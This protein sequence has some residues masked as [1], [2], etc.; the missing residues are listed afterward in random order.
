MNARRVRPA[1]A[2]LAIVVLGALVPAVADAGFVKGSPGGGDPYFPKAG[3]GGYEVSSYNLRLRYKPASNHLAATAVIHARAKKSL[4]RFDLDFRHLRIKRLAVN[5]ERARY[6][7]RG[8][9]LKISPR[10]G[11]RRGSHFRVRVRYGGHPRP[12][13]DPDGAA[14]GWVPTD[15]GAFV[16]A[17]PQG[18]PSWFPCN[19]LLTDK[20]K[21]RIRVTVPK[22]KDAISNGRLVKTVVDGRHKTFVWVEDSPMATYLATVT[23]G[24]FSVQRSRV[25]GIPSVVAIDPREAGAGKVLSRTPAMLRLFEP[26]FGRYPFGNIGGVVDHAP[27]VGYA[28]E[29]QTRPIYDVT[30]DSR[31]VAHELAHQWF[32]DSVSLRRWH[33]IW[34][35]EGFAT[36][37]EW[38]WVQ[39]Q[40]GETTQQVFDRLY[41]RHGP[42]DGSFWNPPPGDPGGPQNLFDA[43]IYTRGG[44]T[45]EAL[46]QEVGK[47]TFFRILRDWAADHAYGNAG[48]KQFIDL[49]ET[50]SDRDLGHFFHV[51]LYRPEKP[52]GWR[53]PRPSRSDRSSGARGGVMEGINRL[54]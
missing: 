39:R 45:L 54:R 16:A 19:D 32:G 25:E 43:T 3:N 22:G 48:T 18:A 51:W 44:M 30:P 17:E 9:E 26:R 42:G 2:G 46:R 13:I 31:T 5:G 24:D 21:Y 10:H 23:T 12:V 28:L 37:A 27:Q 53:G 7:R 52:R 38:S 35:N 36:W 41:R 40:G 49:A 29:T 1:L 8:Q 14:D 50:D 4:S 47:P 20:A 11:L 33:Q 34:L 6:S 15:D